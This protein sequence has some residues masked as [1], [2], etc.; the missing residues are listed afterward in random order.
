MWDST[1]PPPKPLTAGKPKS[2]TEEIALLCK[3]R[4]ESGGI[5]H[6]AKNE[7]DVG[8]PAIG[9]WDGGKTSRKRLNLD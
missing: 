3:M 8:H 5:P 7:R 9:G 2:P 6:L 4:G 1:E